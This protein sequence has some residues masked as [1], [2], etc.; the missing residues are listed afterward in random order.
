[1]I[2][3]L[4]AGFQLLGKCEVLVF[5]NVIKAMS[6]KEYYAIDCKRKEII[7]VSISNVTLTITI[8]VLCFIERT[9]KDYCNVYIRVMP[10]IIIRFRKC[11]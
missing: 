6:N 7:Y 10:V 5:R 3:S 9:Y 1:M 8:I 2:T 4:H 11:G